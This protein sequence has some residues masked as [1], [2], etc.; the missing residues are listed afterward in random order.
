[1]DRKLLA[2]LKTT[3]AL[4]K[5]AGVESG[6]DAE[7]VN[8]IEKLWIAAQEVDS[9]GRRTRAASEALRKLSHPKGSS[10]PLARAVPASQKKSLACLSKAQASVQQ[11]MADMVMAIVY[12]AE[13]EALR[14]A[15]PLL[16]NRK[17]EVPSSSK[18]DDVLWFIDWL[19]QHDVPPY[20]LRRMPEWMKELLAKLMLD[21][22]DTKF[23]NAENLWPRLFHAGVLE[24]RG[25]TPTSD[26]RRLLA[27]AADFRE[28]QE[29]TIR[30][31]LEQ[32]LGR[33]LD[34]SIEFANAIEAIIRER[35]T[36][37]AYEQEL[38]FCAS[39]ERVSAEAT[40]IAAILGEGIDKI[41][42]I[43]AARRSIISTGEVASKIEGDEFAKAVSTIVQA[44]RECDKR[45]YDGRHW[46]EAVATTCQNTFSRYR[47]L[48]TSDTGFWSLMAVSLELSGLFEKYE[49]AKGFAFSDMFVSDGHPTIGSG[50]PDI[51]L[52]TDTCHSS[53]ATGNTHDEFVDAASYDGSDPS[54]NGSSVIVYTPTQSAPPSSR[55]AARRYTQED[56]A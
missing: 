46:P 56:L 53:P 15:Q 37:S 25:I 24:A 35:D 4:A 39:E 50:Q 17:G 16:T 29:E 9:K 6:A 26:E 36:L 13:F 19:K 8:E 33:T 20:I 45:D 1:M 32:R 28:F 5:A 14:D 43:E 27:E 31:R 18:D 42:S 44:I 55:R 22:R 48:D 10:T 51:L 52:E 12:Q 34:V 41:P 30:Q 3:S 54:P 47:R 21:A 23:E 38:L 40:M 2:L 7:A 49:Y 11:A